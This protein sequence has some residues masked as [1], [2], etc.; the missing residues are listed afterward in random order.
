[1]WKNIGLVSLESQAV[2]VREVEFEQPFV[3]DV[4]THCG[5]IF[6]LTVGGRYSECHN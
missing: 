3:L 1:M 6:S 5:S 2:V 4:S